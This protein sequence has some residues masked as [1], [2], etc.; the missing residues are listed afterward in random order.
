MK[1]MQKQ[2][3]KVSIHYPIPVHLTSAF[4][5]LKYPVGCFPEAEKAAQ[6]ILTLPLFPG[7]TEQQQEAVYIALKRAFE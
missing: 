1:F 2:G 6:E 7:I 5:Y 4:S 3:I